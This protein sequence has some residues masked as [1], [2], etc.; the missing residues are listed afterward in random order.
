MHPRVG[1]GLL[2]E[3]PALH[4]V[5]TAIRA[6]HERL[7]GTGYPA[8]LQGDAIP[9]T[10]RVLAV[11]DAY[12]A[13]VH[14]RPH[15]PARSPHDALSE[16]VYGAAVRFDAQVVRALA[17]EI[18]AS[19]A[20]DP[21]LAGAVA[22]AIDTAGLPPRGKFTGT[23]PLT[24]LL[25]HRAFHE[26]AAH[27]AA[28]GTGTVA[29]VEIVGLD[30][31]NRGEGYAAGDR[32]LLAAARATQRAAARVGGSVYRDSG[33]RLAI[34]VART[35]PTSPVLAAELHT[36]FAIGPHVRVGVADWQPGDSGES[37]IE[38]ARATVAPANPAPPTPLTDTEPHE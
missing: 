25:G 7:D 30:E 5:A 18:Q 9:I 4:D 15:R 22:S 14:E 32:A 34:L 21:E 11:V 17:D 37:L 2:E 1:A 31:I 19:V 13:M 24:L 29:I 28:D 23:D 27:A 10:A 33:R 12:S 35:S 16:L 38:R 26:A 3:L 36:E 8:G 20:L 6:H